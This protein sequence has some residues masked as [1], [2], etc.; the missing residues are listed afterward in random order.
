MFH[1]A[2]NNNNCNTYVILNFVCQIFNMPK[3]RNK[4]YN[5]SE[6]RLLIVQDKIEANMQD[7]YNRMK[8]LKE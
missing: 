7:C 5:N 2:S 3:V 1:I 6:E 4:M 8:N